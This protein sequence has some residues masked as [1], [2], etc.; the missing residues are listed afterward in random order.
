MQELKRGKTLRTFTMHFIMSGEFFT[1]QI[2]KLIF[3]KKKDE[4]L[5]YHEPILFRENF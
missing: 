5:A 2:Q 1:E 3:Q 4:P